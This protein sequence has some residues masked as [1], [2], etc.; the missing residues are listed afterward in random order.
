MAD[1]DRH[2]PA[3]PP[4]AAR[5]R[6]RGRSPRRRGRL[7]A[8]ARR[9]CPA[10][11]ES[12]PARSR[13]ARAGSRRLHDRDAVAHRH[14]ALLEQRRAHLFEEKRI[15]ASAVVQPARQGA[16]YLAHPERRLDDR[17]GGGEVEPLEAHER[18]RRRPAIRGGL[19]RAARHD[20]LRG[21]GGGEIRHAGEGRRDPVSDQCQSSTRTR[22]GSEPCQR[23]D[24]RCE[25][26]EQRRLKMFAA[27]MS[28]STWTSLSPTEDEIKRQEPLERGVQRAHPR[29]TVRAGQRRMK[30]E[31][32]AQNLD[33]H[34]IG[35]AVA[36]GPAT[37]LRRV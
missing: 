9:G 33:E 16:G 22:S 5:N 31:T 37:R 3:R 12:R 34:A 30:I 32:F 2:R 15:A 1:R 4:R 23:S 36:V 13:A 28:A 11:R 6:I 29:A 10:G 27:Q 18:R 8:P 14:R 24:G 26:V 7:R 17:G 25:R 35:H 19:I 21:E 20:Q